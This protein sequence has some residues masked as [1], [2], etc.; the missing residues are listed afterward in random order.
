MDLIIREIRKMRTEGK[1]DR[2]ML[3]REQTQITKEI[4]AIKE[5]VKAREKK[6]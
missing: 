6:W 2:E 5:E 4:E 3:K 1:E